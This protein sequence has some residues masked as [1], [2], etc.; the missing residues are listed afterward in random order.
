MQE[1]DLCKS[2]INTE[3]KEELIE[4]LEK[5]PKLYARKDADVGKT[6]LVYHGINTEDHV[7]GS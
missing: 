4:I 2:P 6:D 7:P 5:Y 3:E 1:I